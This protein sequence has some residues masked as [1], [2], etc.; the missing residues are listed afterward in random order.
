M[1]RINRAFLKLKEKQTS[2]G[3]VIILNTC[4]TGK[5]YEKMAIGKAFKA[6][7]NKDDYDAEDYDELLDF[8]YSLTCEEPKK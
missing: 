4:V 7:V 3:D 2:W 1:N 6:L 5:C 8:A